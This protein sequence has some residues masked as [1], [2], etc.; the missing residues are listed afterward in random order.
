MSDKSRLSVTIKPA[1]EKSKITHQRTIRITH[2]AQISIIIEE[3]MIERFT[4]D[5]RINFGQ[6]SVRN[7]DI[8]ETKSI[9][10]S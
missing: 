8:L 1:S 3:L 7:V 5:V 4:G 9:V 6:G 10:P 2:P